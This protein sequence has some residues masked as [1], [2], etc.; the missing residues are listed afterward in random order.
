MLP[1]PV[2]VAAVTVERARDAQHGDFASN[3]AMRL[4]KPAGRNPRELAAAIIAALPAN[5]LISRAE[6]AGAGFI[7]L[8]LAKDRYAREMLRVHE[9]GD[10]Y[11]RNEPAQR[12]KVLL[13]FVYDNPT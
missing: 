11:G 12:R 6:V 10:R 9:L 3:V 1:G 13:E 2:D 4:A 5:T 7:N 8:H